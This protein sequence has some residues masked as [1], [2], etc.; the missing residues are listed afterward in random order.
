MAALVLDEHLTVVAGPPTVFYDLAQSAVPL[1]DSCRLAITGSAEVS[2]DSLRATCDQL[3][4][5]EVVVGYGLT[6]AAGT[7]ALD[8]LRRGMDEVW[9]TP[10]TDVDVCIVDDGG[11]AVDVGTTG[12]ILVRGFNVCRRNPA[13]PARSP[14]DWLDTGDLGRMDQTGRLLIESRRDDMVIVNGLNVYPHEV[15]AVLL[16]HP[17]VAAAAVIGQPDARQGRRL[18]AAVVMVAG[19]TAVEAE[20]VAHCRKAL[21]SFK[22]PRRVIALAQLPL[23]TTGKFS[24]SVLR[25]RLEEENT[26][27]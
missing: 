15:E 22:V 27:V 2:A 11:A 5:A 19:H 12:R 23:T 10:L 9:M 18:V 4:I 3:G 16:D 6:E 13:D 17:T 21:A 14:A 24:R 7:V 20:L 25:R 1:G 8:R 26:D